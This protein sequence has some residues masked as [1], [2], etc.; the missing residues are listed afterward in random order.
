MWICGGIEEEKAEDQGYNNNNKINFMLSNNCIYC[1]IHLL[2]FSC[3]FGL[4]F[5]LLG[6]LQCLGCEAAGH[7]IGFLFEASQ[8]EKE[9]LEQ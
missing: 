4:L 2:V 6:L 9:H 8:R 7:T 3:I 1:R 5:E